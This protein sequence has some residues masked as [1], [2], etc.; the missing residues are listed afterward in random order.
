MRLRRGNDAA[1]ALRRRGSSDTT[2]PFAR[3]LACSARCAGGYGTSTPRA[4]HGDGSPRRRPAR[5]DARRRRCRAPCRSR[6]TAPARASAA[7]ISRVTR[8]AV[9]GGASRVPTIATTG[10]AS[11]VAVAQRTETRAARRQVEQRPGYSAR[12]ITTDPR[13]ARCATLRRVTLH[14]LRRTRRASDPRARAVRNAAR[15]TATARAPARDAPTPRRASAR[16][17]DGVARSTAGERRV[18]TALALFA[19]R[20]QLVHHAA[21]SASSPVRAAALIAKIAE[22]VRRLDGRHVLLA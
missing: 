18:F 9:R 17:R 7:A 12:P 1:V 13:I 16:D 22:R 6:R 2:Q 4:E 14:R 5:R 11:S 8:C 20:E 19:Q 21:S 10:A 3:D 15:R